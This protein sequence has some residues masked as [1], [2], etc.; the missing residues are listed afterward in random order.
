MAAG[1]ALGKLGQAG[2][3]ARE[4]EIGFGLIKSIQTGDGK[5][6]ESA[7]TVVSVAEEYSL[8]RVLGRRVTR[9]SLV[10]K[11]GHFFDVL[12]TVD[13]QGRPSVDFFMIDRV[14]AAEAKA[15]A[16]KP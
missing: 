13:L 10:R 6:A 14:M 11:D 12:D 2:P 1:F 5:T 7:F 16:P 3:S 9:Q 8:M 4:E 15:F